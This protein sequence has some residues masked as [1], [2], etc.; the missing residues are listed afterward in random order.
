MMILFFIKKKIMMHLD[1]QKKKRKMN[2]M[3]NFHF[4][5][6]VF[7]LDL[8]RCEVIWVRRTQEA[9]FGGYN[10]DRTNEESW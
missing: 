3:L 8:D 7:C 4:P 10:L 6:S 9:N 5:I 2:F 1:K